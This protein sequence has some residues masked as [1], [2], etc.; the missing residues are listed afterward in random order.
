MKSNMKNYFQRVWV[1]AIAVMLC[2]SALSSC[3]TNEEYEFEFE[4]PGRIVSQLGAT[5]EVPFKAVNIS[6]MSIVDVPDGW[7]V[8]DVD[9]IKCTM[10]V[11]APKEFASEDNDIE[12]NGLLKVSGFTAAGSTLHITSY[13][14][15]L[16]NSIDLT[17]DYANSYVISQKHTRYTIDVTHKGET[18]ERVTP[19]RVDVIWQSDTYLVDYDS[20]DAEAGTYTFY[21]GAEDVKDEAGNVTGTRLPYGNAVVGAYDADDNIIW[22]WHL[23]LTDDVETSAITTSSGV[24]MDRNLGACYNSNGS[25]DTDDIYASYG[26]YYQWGR[27]DPFL[28][29]KDYKFTDNRDEIVYSGTGSTK[30]F[31]YVTADMVSGEVRENAFGSMGY[32]I[33]DPFTFILGTAQNDY[34]WLH[35]S[36]DAALWSADVKS[37]NDPC[38]RGWRV[39]DGEA[40]KAFDID[41]EEDAAALADV[42]NMYGW[43]LVDKTTGVRMFM[44]GAG[45][46]SFETGVL[47]N[48]NNYG[49]EHVP[50]PW[51]GYYWTA[52]ATSGNKSVSM[53]FDLNTT[54]A[55]N[56]GYQSQKAMY[57]GNGMQV[58]CV[59]VK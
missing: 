58:R 31:R 25:T 51:V 30:L 9:L 32:A 4:L 56:N 3:S 35:G 46:R 57:R 14:S 29:P 49:Y 8:T 10:K 36:H 59:K 26:L 19:A 12:E 1:A 24:F 37:V 52:T 47:T 22:S 54:R 44:P 21:V 38:P 40:F 48:L 2:V 20:Y 17:D 27:K 34:D 42:K 15:L 43:H 45:R 7:E 6:S 50:A 16:N 5:I 41:V 55:V 11:S 23:W 13:L 53:F 18:S 28:R 39:P 33:D